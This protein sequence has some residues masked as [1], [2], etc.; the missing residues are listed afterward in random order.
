MAG[1]ILNSLRVNF[2]TIII[3]VVIALFSS[4]LTFGLNKRLSDYDE[5][6]QDLK[7]KASIIYVDKQFEHHREMSVLEDSRVR[8]MEI[9]INEIHQILMKG[10][11]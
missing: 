4:V 1:R 7:A 9:Q 2:I 8:N 11:L 5:I 6:K 3:G 10:H